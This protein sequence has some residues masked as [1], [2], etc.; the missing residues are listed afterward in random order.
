MKIKKIFCFILLLILAYRI[1]ALN[2]DQNAY[3]DYLENN[4]DFTVKSGDSLEA[5]KV[6]GYSGKIIL[7]P[8][9]YAEMPENFAG[10]I[11]LNDA[12]VK[13][14]N[15]RIVKGKGLCD[16]S[17][18][19]ILE[20]ESGEGFNKVSDGQFRIKEDGKI[21]ILT[22]AR[23]GDGEYATYLSSIRNLEFNS[24]NYKF[25]T[26]KS[27]EVAGVVL[28]TEGTVLFDPQTNSLKPSIDNPTKNDLFIVGYIDQTKKPINFIRDNVDIQLARGMFLTKGSSR[29]IFEEVDCDNCILLKNDKIK[30]KGDGFTLRFNEEKSV[31]NID[32]QNTKKRILEISPHQGGIIEIKNRINHKEGVMDTITKQAPKITV[33]GDDSNEI[34]AEIKNDGTTLDAGKDGILNYR[35]KKNVPSDDVIP[36]ELNIVNGEGESLLRTNKGNEL[37]VSFDLNSV[38]HFSTL[39]AHVSTKGEPDCGSLTANFCRDNFFKFNRISALAAALDSARDEFESNKIKMHDFK[40]EYERSLES[41]SLA[42]GLDKKIAPNRG[43]ED[44]QI[45]IMKQVPSYTRIRLFVPDESRIE[46]IKGLVDEE[47]FS[48]I[49]FII[50]PSLRG[51]E[52]LQDS[53]K[54][55]E[56]VQFLPLTRLGGSFGSKDPLNP[57]N[58]YVY[59][60]EQFGTEVR[61]VPIQFQGGNIIISRNNY[62]EK[63]LLIGSDDYAYTRDTY[64]EAGKSISENEYQQILREAFNVD[65]VD[66]IGIKNSNGDFEKQ[67]AFLFHLDQFVLPLE[68]GVIAMPAVESDKPAITKDEV[69]SQKHQEEKLLAIKWQLEDINSVARSWTEEQK[70]QFNRERVELNR[71]FDKLLAVIGSYEAKER[72][73]SYR[74][75]MKEKGFRIVDLKADLS[76]IQNYQA[77]TNSI[78][79]KDKNTGEKT[80]IMPIFPDK[81]GE[82]TLE[83]YN[84]NN[85]ETFKKEGYQVKVARDKGFHNQGNIHCLTL[86]AQNRQ[87]PPNFCPLA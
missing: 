53:S 76:N 14:P 38:L 27:S 43:I 45:E 59:D 18:C 82:Y 51:Y 44:T 26:I 32:S 87:N 25:N 61:R 70:T 64:R 77:F 10:T 20:G 71:K 50:N 63:I 58:I 56:K 29:I 13:M 22:N 15:G 17:G 74:D 68:D 83:G 16:K 40:P 1:Q 57:K 55:D 84:L 42:L 47:I 36:L 67:N 11:V 33:S 5:Q 3:K 46:R 79:Y 72:L 30:I 62:G 19:T 81:N 24:G 41:V 60:L 49:D 2:D 37:K 73:D 8:N 66:I 9:S 78:V 69:I 4:K 35:V 48:R 54:G 65:N 28:E 39:N 21:D 7:S 52:W 12:T 34:W 75:L 85:F 86:L 6:Q 31:L 23:I 80:I